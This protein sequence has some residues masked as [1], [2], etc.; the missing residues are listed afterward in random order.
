[1]EHIVKAFERMGAKAKVITPNREDRQPAGLRLDVKNDTWGK[2]YFDVRLARY[3]DL[4]VITVEPKGR[5]LLLQGEWNGEK[6]KFLCG[7]DER[8]WFVAAIPETARGV[9]DV[10]S[11]MEAL[12][13]PEVRER[14]I[15]VGLP[16]A[17]RRKR[18]NKAFV[19]QGEWFFVPTD[20]KVADDLLITQNGVLRRGAG[21]SHIAE[22]EYRRD[23]T[24]VFVHHSFA[25]N[26]I[27]PETYDRWQRG[28]LGEERR[29]Q[30]ISMFWN[31]MLRDPI[32]YVRGKISH[33]D[34]ATI[35][36]GDR[37]HRVHMNTE[38]KAK[39]M[40]HVAFLD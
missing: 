37:W 38:T 33:P 26:G 28:E 18:R 29:K 27:T 12:K 14:Q 17:H 3:T 31:Q 39:A 20:L 19:R 9:K 30:A 10:P 8:N 34:H 6:H 11:A 24:E 2:P 35:D 7:H 4:R 1:M 21:K 40:R 25:P 15:A 16:R 22:Q 23:G 36:L 13:P 5:H 32:V